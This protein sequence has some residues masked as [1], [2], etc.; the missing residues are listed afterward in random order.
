MPQDLADV[1]RDLLEAH[2]AE[3][4]VDLSRV[5]RLHRTLE[6]Y[7]SSDASDHVVGLLEAACAE[8][9]SGYEGMVLDAVERVALRS[10]DLGV[11]DLVTVVGRDTDFR[12]LNR[13]LRETRAMFGEEVPT[14]QVSTHLRQGRRV[15]PHSRYVGFGHLADVPTAGRPAVVGEVLA[16]LA[17]PRRRHSR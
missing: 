8:C 9:I 13:A 10:P 2:Q 6:R 7:R 17:G 1:L 15:G 3:P 11:D 16:R 12:R 14:V 4:V 5:R